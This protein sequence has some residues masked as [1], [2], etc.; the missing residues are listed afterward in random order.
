TRFVR[1]DITA[2]TGW[3]AAQLSE[4]EVRG[5]GGSS[6][7]LAAGKTLTASSTNRSRTP[8]DANDGNRDSYWASREGQF[9]QWIQADLGASLGVDRVVLRLPDGWTARSQTLKL[10]GS[11]NGTDFTD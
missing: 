1:V 8:A 7:D 6:A 2:N 4:L 10:Q 9:P 11:A 5:A 3:S